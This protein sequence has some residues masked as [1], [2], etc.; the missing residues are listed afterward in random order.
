MAFPVIFGRLAFTGYEDEG[1]EFSKDAKSWNQDSWFILLS[2]SN[3]VLAW[4]QERGVIDVDE[5]KSCFGATNGV[6]IS[7]VPTFNPIQPNVSSLVMAN[8]DR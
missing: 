6:S 1:G 2:S 8:L 4:V 3:L 5:K 7:V